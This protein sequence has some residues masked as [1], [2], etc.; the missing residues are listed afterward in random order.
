[1]SLPDFLMHIV[2][3]QDTWQNHCL[4]CCPIGNLEIREMA[5]YLLHKLTKNLMQR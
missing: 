4:L 1:M 3:M 5:L 2:L